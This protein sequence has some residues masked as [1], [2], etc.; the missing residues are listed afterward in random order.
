MLFIREEYTGLVCENIMV[1]VSSIWQNLEFRHCLLL[2]VYFVEDTL[3][4]GIPGDYANPNAPAA[5]SEVRKLVD[6]GQYAEATTEAEKLSG[7]PS[8]VC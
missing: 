3:W 5:L 2:F 6:N 7:E 4:T 1:S 8:D